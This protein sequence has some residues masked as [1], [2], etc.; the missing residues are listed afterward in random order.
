MLKNKTPGSYSRG[1][2]LCLLCDSYGLEPDGSP[3]I[4]EL[5]EQLRAF[6]GFSPTE[7]ATAAHTYS[8]NWSRITSI[9]LSP[10][11][12]GVAGISSVLPSR[13]GRTSR[14]TV[15]RLGRRDSRR[16]HWDTGLSRALYWPAAWRYLPRTPS[17]ELVASLQIRI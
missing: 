8:Q 17:R 10:A 14:V 13:R 1:F 9:S 7:A 2:E 16:V 15:D 3:A 11:G 6:A 5:R 4:T 12:R